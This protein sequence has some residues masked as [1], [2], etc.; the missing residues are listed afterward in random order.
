ML[1]I[2]NSLSRM[3]FVICNSLSCMALCLTLTA[4]CWSLRVVIHETCPWIFYLIRAFSLIP[5]P[6]QLHR[7]KQTFIIQ[8]ELSLLYISLFSNSNTFWNSFTAITRLFSSFSLLLEFRLFVTKMSEWCSRFNKR[9]G[10]IQYMTANI[11]SALDCCWLS[12]KCQLL[13]SRHR[14]CIVSSSLHQL[15]IRVNLGKFHRRCRKELLILCSYLWLY[16]ML[17]W[18]I[19]PPPPWPMTHKQDSSIVDNKIFPL[20]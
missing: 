14:L 6:K 15:F 3:V 17:V 1:H 18:Y 8:S 2:H 10:S 11:L 9:V 16:L 19:E 5:R 13:E 20:E 7:L 12:M 4:L